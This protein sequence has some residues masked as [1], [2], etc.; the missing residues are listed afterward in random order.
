MKRSGRKDSGSS[1]ISGFLVIPLRDIV[2]RPKPMAIGGEIKIQTICLPLRANPLEYDIQGIDHLE[3]MYGGRL[4]RKKVSISYI[5]EKPGSIPKVAGGCHLHY[6]F[7][8]GGSCRKLEVTCLYNSVTSA[9]RYGRELRSAR[10]GS[11]SRPM[12]RSI[13]S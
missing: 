12:T 1:Y 10:T 2:E 8:K 11:R 4:W 6:T 3:L 13:S 7:K 9:S 5:M